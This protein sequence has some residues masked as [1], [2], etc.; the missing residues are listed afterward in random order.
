MTK[1]VFFGLLYS[2]LFQH[3]RFWKSSCLCSESGSCSVLSDSLQSR[4]LYGPWNSLSLNTE[5]GS[6]SPLQGYSQPRD[7]TQ[8]S[9][10]AGRFFTS[11]A[12][13]E[14]W[15][16]WRIHAKHLLMGCDLLRPP[17]QPNEECTV[18]NSLYRWEDWG[19]PSLNN[20]PKVTEW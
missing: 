8:V 17:K 4:G 1:G 18:I 2:F 20:L 7:R 13:R 14:T 11:W 5:V 9:Y 3:C 19:T 6:L 12:T 15:C 10:S 16:L